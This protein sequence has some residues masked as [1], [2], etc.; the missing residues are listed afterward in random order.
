MPQRYA[1][2]LILTIVLGFMFLY[3]QFVEYCEINFSIIDSCFG[4]I[5]FFGTGAHGLHVGLGVLIILGRGSSAYFFITDR[6]SHSGLLFS[7]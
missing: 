1:L 2:S 6:S 7:I 5:F 4:S 3:F